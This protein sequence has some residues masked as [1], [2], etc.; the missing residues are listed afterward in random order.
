MNKVFLK[1]LKPPPFAAIE[2]IVDTTTDSA[3]QTPRLLIVLFEDRPLESVTRMADAACETGN[4]LLIIG[5]AERSFVPHA[6]NLHV[7]EKKTART[8]GVVRTAIQTAIRLKATHLMTLGAMAE[9]TADDLAVI[10]A[11]VHDKPDAVIVGRP[12]PAVA[13]NSRRTRWRRRWGNFWYRM[14]TGISLDDIRAG[15]C[16][17][18]LTVLDIL[19]FNSHP[20]IFEIQA[21]VKAAWAGVEIEQVMVPGLERQ[22]VRRL[23]WTEAIMRGV[24]TVHLTMRAIT[25]LPHPKIVHDSKEPNKKISVIHPLRS[26]KALLTENTTPWQ[27]CLATAM[28]VFMGALPL[29]AVHTIVIL[30]A[31][32]FFRLNK[33]AALAASQLC[34]P[35]IVPALCIEA[36]YYLRFGEFLTEI[37][38]ET[39]GYQAI[40]RL[41]EWLL[42]SLLMGPGLAVIAGAVVYLAAI[43]IRRNLGSTPQAN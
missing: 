19:A 29:I 21:P 16:I 17:Y 34:M 6:S 33:V 28:G 10:A 35:P 23:S 31:A 37:S 3:A 14:Q 32:G 2:S 36:G 20:A 30:F 42:G 12:D 18:P 15:L 1:P 27:L 38:I 11:S 26:I 25:P 41:Y 5:T 39:L 7:V 13:T 43:M 40:D 4:H 8:R 24:M 22:I 9:L